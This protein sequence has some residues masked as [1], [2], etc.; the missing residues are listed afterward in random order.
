MLACRNRLANWNS[1]ILF[2]YEEKEKESDPCEHQMDDGIRCNRPWFW[3]PAQSRRF[4]WFTFRMTPPSILKVILCFQ[5][6]ERGRPSPV[7][8]VPAGFSV[9]PGSEAFA[10]TGGIPRVSYL[11]GQKT[12]LVFGSRLWLLVFGANIQPL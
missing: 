7:P 1:L 2:K 10:K 4:W 3:P 9:L 12:Q 5:A 8:E 11:V 6:S